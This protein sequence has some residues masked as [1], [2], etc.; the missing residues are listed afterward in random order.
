[1]FK[2]DEKKIKFSVILFFILF[3]FSFL[4][5]DTNDK[6]LLNYSLCKKD[7]FINRHNIENLEFLPKNIIINFSNSQKWYQ[8]LFKL[9]Q[10]LGNPKH[11]HTIKIPTE[12]KRYSFVDVN[13]EFNNGTECVFK[14][15][16]RIH[17]GRGDHIANNDF[18]SSLNVKILDGNINNI[19]EFILFLPQTRSGNNEIFI[20]LLLEKM[21]ILSPFTTN[22]NVKINNSDF[23]T[24]LFQEKINSNFLKRNQKPNGVIMSLNKTYQIKNVANDFDPRFD[25]LSRVANSEKLNNSDYINAVDNL[26]YLLIENYNL[27]FYNESFNQVFDYER[28]FENIEAGNKNKKRINYEKFSIFQA[29]QISTGAVHSLSIDDSKYYLNNLYNILEPIYYDGMPKILEGY[30]LK[31]DKGFTNKTPEYLKEVSN[32]LINFLKT[33]DYYEFKK[34]LKIRNFNISDEG[35]KSAIDNIIFNLQTI[36]SSEKID[37]TDKNI[38][39]TKYKFF[40]KIK[41]KELVKLVFGGDNN[42]IEICDINLKSCNNKKINK[43]KLKSLLRNH[44]LK[45][46]S[47]N[48]FYVR[49]SKKDFIENKK[50]EKYGLE[51]FETYRINSNQN[52]YFKQRIHG[53]GTSMARITT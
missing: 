43:N 39:F 41:D 35:L 28:K 30:S 34:D 17:G 46:D 36:R 4:N 48:L 40:D 50:P 53:D 42:L 49:R 37:L 3:N 1:M 13:V 10:F 5:A 21:N 2:I 32:K 25:R 31:D 38:N 26:N 11:K 23:H 22:T 52:I 7:T 47:E 27:N 14:G 19:T 15:Q 18:I 44:I 51:T 33:I 29:I 6:K 8:N 12:Y 16:A 9:T 24:F 45:L 20:T